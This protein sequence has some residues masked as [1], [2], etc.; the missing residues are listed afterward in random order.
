MESSEKYMTLENSRRLTEE[1]ILDSLKKD[2]GFDLLIFQT[3][4]TEGTLTGE[5]VEKLL[6]DQG[7]LSK[8][9]PDYALLTNGQLNAW[10]FIRKKIK[11][12]GDYPGPAGV[13]PLFRIGCSG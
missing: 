8:E 13:K 11:K 4:L 12:S 6:Y 3:M 2:S 1:M 10:Q 9:D 7:I 5:D